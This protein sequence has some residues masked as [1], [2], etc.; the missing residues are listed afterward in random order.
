[1][2]CVTG[3]RWVRGHAD[4]RK[5]NE[6]SLDLNRHQ[7]ERRVHQ[8]EFKFQTTVS[9]FLGKSFKTQFPFVVKW[10]LSLLS[11][12]TWMKNEKLMKSYSLCCNVSGAA[13]WQGCK[14]MKSLQENLYVGELLQHFHKKIC[15]VSS[16]VIVVLS[17]IRTELTIMQNKCMMGNFWRENFQ[18]KFVAILVL[19]NFLKNII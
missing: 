18:N 6:R 13:K 19:L 5:H 16:D 3:S 4:I 15:S 17:F 11:S 1:M 2:L 12:W 8:F 9:D 7:V 10:N 14:Q